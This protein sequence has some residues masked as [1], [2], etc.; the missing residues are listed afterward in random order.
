MTTIRK[1]KY[2]LIISLL[3]TLFGCNSNQPANKKQEKSDT[4]ALT[5]SQIDTFYYWNI[6]NSKVV[7]DFTWDTNDYSRLFSD[8]TMSKCFVKLDTNQMRQ[9]VS[10]ILNIESNYVV[11]YM[12][13]HLIS[14][15]DKI[16]N[17]NP[18]IVF[19][20]GD[21]YGA[22]IYILL[23]KENKPVSHFVMHGGF[24]GG[25]YQLNDSTQ[26]H[27][28]IIHSTI[29]KDII[30]SY[31]LKYFDKLDTITRPSIIDSISYLIKIKENGKLE[32]KKIDS[33]RFSRIIRDRRN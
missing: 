22:L 29:S 31:T 27:C 18:I 11:E 16:Y 17:Y 14:K 9:I 23:D 7:F 21:D 26:G 24:C 32:T 19:V 13:G 15:Q 12:Y 28:P 8:T 20:N 2:I 4:A 5:T 10:P 6:Q 25:D 1:M 3:T 33:V 30:N